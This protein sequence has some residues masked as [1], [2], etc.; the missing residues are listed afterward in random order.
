LLEVGRGMLAVRCRQRPEF[1]LDARQLG[2]E[3]A[4]VVP[5]A[6]P[7]RRLH[8]GHRFGDMTRVPVPVGQHSEE[9]GQVQAETGFREL[10]NRCFADREQRGVEAVATNM[11]DSKAAA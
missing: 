7:Q 10:P 1:S 4:L 8:R 6:P 11:P 3:S 9:H 5:L 2:H